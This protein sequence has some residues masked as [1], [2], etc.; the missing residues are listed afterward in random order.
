MTQHKK[1]KI[2]NKKRER[3]KEK[4]RKMEPCFA[5]VI[6]GFLTPISITEL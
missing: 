2:K 4:K 6:V 1:I 5:V 3:R